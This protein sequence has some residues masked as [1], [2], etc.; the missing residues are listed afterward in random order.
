M[1]AQIQTNEAGTSELADVVRT[2]LDGYL[3][4]ALS[5]VKDKVPTNGGWS[6]DALSG[7]I[8]GALSAWDALVTSDACA[9]EGILGEV[10]YQDSLLAQRL[11]GAGG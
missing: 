3:G 2:S 11:M 1:P 7:G 9:I 5:P 4:F 8:V 10:V 6:H